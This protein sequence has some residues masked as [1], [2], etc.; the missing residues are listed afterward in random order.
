MFFTNEENHASR[1]ISPHALDA[2]GKTETFIQQTTRGCKNLKKSL[3]LHRRHLRMETLWWDGAQAAT[4]KGGKRRRR[5]SGRRRK[6]RWVSMISIEKKTDNELKTKI[7]YPKEH[8]RA[9]RYH[10]LSTHKLVW[11][12]RRDSR[13]RGHILKKCRR[14][15]GVFARCRK[16]YRRRSSKVDQIG[17]AAHA[18][19]RQ[20]QMSL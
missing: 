15:A 6:Y 8:R 9:L 14:L 7:C 12:N 5:C 1:Q 17:I 2:I 4:S 3:K 20:L 13:F 11:D 18:I 16:M 19:T 10:I